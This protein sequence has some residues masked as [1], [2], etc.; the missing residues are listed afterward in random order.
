MFGISPEADVTVKNPK[1]FQLEVG[2]L[3]TS[4]FVVFYIYMAEYFLSVVNILAPIKRV[5]MM[6]LSL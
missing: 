4:C 3:T 6:H 1:Q 2:I 5:E